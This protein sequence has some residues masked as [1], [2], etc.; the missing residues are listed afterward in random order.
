[1]REKERTERETVFEREREREREIQSLFSI[2]VTSLREGN[3]GFG[4]QPHTV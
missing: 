4:E 2:R 1:M 3:S